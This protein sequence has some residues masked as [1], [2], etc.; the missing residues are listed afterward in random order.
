[1]VDYLCLDDFSGGIKNLNFLSEF[2]FHQKKL[3]RIMKNKDK[4]YTDDIK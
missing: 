4:L 2:I 1:V 3:K